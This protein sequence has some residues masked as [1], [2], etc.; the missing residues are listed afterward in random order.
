MVDVGRLIDARQDAIDAAIA[1]VRYLKTIHLGSN[2]RGV[3]D[4][5]HVVSRLYGTVREIVRDILA[6]IAAEKTIRHHWTSLQ[7]HMQRWLKPHRALISREIEKFP[8]DSQERFWAALNGWPGRENASKLYTVLVDRLGVPPPSVGDPS[9]YGDEDF[10]TDAFAETWGNNVRNYEGL[11][12]RSD[13]IIGRWE[14]RFRGREDRPRPKGKFSAERWGYDKEGLIAAGRLDP[15]YAAQ[16]F[17]DAIAWLEKARSA[18]A[19]GISE[20]VSALQDVSTGLDSLGS[21]RLADA[22]DLAFS[23]SSLVGKGLVDEEAAEVKSRRSAR[24]QA[25]PNPRRAR[26]NPDAEG[27][28][29]QFEQ[30]MFEQIRA[31]ELAIKAM[32]KAIERRSPGE[33]DLAQ[34]TFIMGVAH[35]LAA[36]A[37]ILKAIG[38]HKTRLG[39][40]RSGETYFMGAKG[41]WAE[42]KEEEKRAKHRATPSQIAAHSFKKKWNT[43]DLNDAD[44]FLRN[45]EVRLGHA[46]SLLRSN[47]EDASMQ[48]IRKA[49]GFVEIAARAIKHRDSEQRLEYAVSELPNRV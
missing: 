15:T 49:V 19:R 38:E 17:D 47:F 14:K 2:R 29:S 12:L 33:L 8:Q 23:R 25:R 32:R 6:A 26:R 13:R 5:E 35:V 4:Q 28:Y 9:I 7:G 46:A 30:D 18:P 22:V 36:S 34:P 24:K 16:H 40:P 11:A 21:K 48:E 27:N 10:F 39:F 42:A 41:L 44:Q 20:L 43:K 37:R 3:M 31:M 45:A 1:N